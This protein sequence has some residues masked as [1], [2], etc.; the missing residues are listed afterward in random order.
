MKLNE[1]H[2][3][4]RLKCVRGKLKRFI[5]IGFDDKWTELSTFSVR[6]ISQR[7]RDKP[8]AVS[9]R[10]KNRVQAQK[11]S[12]KRTRI[13]DGFNARQRTRFF[14]TAVSQIAYQYAASRV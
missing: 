6:I 11:R 4:S 12:Q 7:S 13:F 8:A 2:S 3:K 1:L 10:D 9:P 14:S 5:L